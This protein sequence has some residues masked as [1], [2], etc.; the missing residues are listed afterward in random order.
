MATR[1]RASWGWSL[2]PWVRTETSAG[3]K[4]VVKH[5]YFDRLTQ[6]SFWVKV[7]TLRFDFI[8]SLLR[9]AG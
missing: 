3:K 6:R 8:D 5:Y 1:I 4:A 7:L 9:I 2:N